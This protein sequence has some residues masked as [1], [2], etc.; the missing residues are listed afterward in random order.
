MARIVVPGHGPLARPEAVRD[1]KGYFEYLSAEAR[2]RFEAG[3]TPLD[4]A[5]DIDLGPYAGWRDEERLVVNIQALYREFGADELVLYCYADDV[6][7][8]EALAMAVRQL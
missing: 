5:R 8:V 7:Q 2:V 1:M 4:A 3:L 6:D